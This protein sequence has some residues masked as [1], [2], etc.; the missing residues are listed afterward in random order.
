MTLQQRTERTMLNTWKWP[1]FLWSVVMCVSVITRLYAKHIPFPDMTYFRPRAASKQNLKD[2]RELPA[3]RFCS[4]M[5]MNADAYS[6]S[7]ARWIVY[8]NARCDCAV[9]AL[10]G[11]KKKKLLGDLTV[12][13][14]SRQGWWFLCDSHLQS[15]FKR[16]WQHELIQI[17][18]V[19][20]G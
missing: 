3:F 17:I 14:L 8:I 18:A 2:K 1:Q 20:P 6:A 10:W 15:G 19:W 16:I 13:S 4:Q 5:R 7:W 12:H 9:S 11:K